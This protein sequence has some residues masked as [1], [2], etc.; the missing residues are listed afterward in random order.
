MREDIPNTQTGEIVVIKILPSG[1]AF[2]VIP[3]TGEE[4]FITSRVAASAGAKIGGLFKA[5][6]LPNDRVERT[7]WFAVWL[8]PA[9]QPVNEEELRTRLWDMIWGRGLTTEDECLDDLVGYLR[10]L[11][12]QIAVD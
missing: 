4:M 3:E 10:D 8:Q 9:R 7:K 12:V 6:Y 2:G 11:G 5:Q 1:A